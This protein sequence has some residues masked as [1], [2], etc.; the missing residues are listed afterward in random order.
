MSGAG[1]QAWAGRFVEPTPIRRLGAIEYVACRAR[2]GARR[3]LVAA[4]P[5]APRDASA[6]LLASIARAHALLDEP[7]VPK[8]AEIDDDPRPRWIALA[9]DAVVDFETLA[10]EVIARRHVVDHGGAVAFAIALCELLDRVHR[11]QDPETGRPLC[12]GAFCT[13]NFL[14]N[15][16]GR[17]WVVGFGHPFRG[18]ARAALLGGAPTSYFA[19]EEAF[20]VP[21]SPPA[22]RARRRTPR[23]SRPSSRSCRTRTRRGPKTG[24][25]RSS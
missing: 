15:E 16:E 10:A 4:T 19:P 2:D 24:P 8:F 3:V 22:S 5:D 17:V 18:A 11:V 23:C 1:G 9:C 25:S 14:A 20:G 7:D 12:L 21:P 6:E 13:A